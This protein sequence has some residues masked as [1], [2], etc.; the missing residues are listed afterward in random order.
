M[1]QERSREDSETCSE[2][3]VEEPPMYKVIL[4]NDDYTP[5]E[6]VVNIL[7]LVF[8]KEK[9]EATELMLA[10]HHQGQAVCGV[11]TKE[12]A[13]TKVDSVRTLAKASKYPLR[14]KLEEA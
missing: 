8:H 9:S 6:F 4:L 5:M 2:L 13:E 11:Y 12:T 7:I 10:V 1:P 14:C 3:E